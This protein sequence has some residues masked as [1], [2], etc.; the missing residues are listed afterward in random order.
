M[1]SQNIIAM[2]YSTSY[3]QR[4]VIGVGS[5]KFGIKIKNFTLNIFDYRTPDQDLGI[6]KSQ[7]I[8]YCLIIGI[9]SKENPFDNQFKLMRSV[10]SAL[11]LNPTLGQNGGENFY[12][13]L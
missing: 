9:W 12:N 11:N 8:I 7:N 3:E 1:S 10:I 6:P 4:S 2:I 13:I 5:P